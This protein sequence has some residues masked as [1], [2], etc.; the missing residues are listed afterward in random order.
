MKHGE[1]ASADRPPPSPPLGRLGRVSGGA[2]EC[3]PKVSL[4]Q[5]SCQPSGLVTP[6][7]VLAGA[8]PAMGSDGR[9]AELVMAVRDKQR[10]EELTH[11]Q[12]ELRVR[13]RFLL[14]LGVDGRGVEPTKRSFG[15]R[16]GPL[17]ELIGAHL[18]SW[19]RL[20][21]C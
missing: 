12:P 3:A 18:A 19:P 20:N 11:V 5:P 7:R 15:W 10:V 2:H 6:A 13:A 9:E 17:G 21:K 1:L 4:A 8:L 16:R 14:K